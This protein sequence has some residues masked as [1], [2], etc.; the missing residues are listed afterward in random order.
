M[1]EMQSSSAEHRRKRGWCSMRRYAV[2]GIPL[3][4]RVGAFN[5]VNGRGACLILTKT[6][7]AIKGGTRTDETLANRDIP[8]AVNTRTSRPSTLFSTVSR[9]PSNHRFFV[10][11]FCRVC[12]CRLPRGWWRGRAG[13]GRRGCS[14]RTTAPPR[15]RWPSRWVSGA[16]FVHSGVHEKKKHGSVWDNELASR[17]LPGSKGVLSCPVLVSRPVLLRR[18]LFGKCVKTRPPW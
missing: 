2:P 15:P 9:H 4:G 5:T 14:S 18:P 13:A 6:T 17:V 12:A 16:T 3:C 10:L 1:Q 8:P 11:V 7:H